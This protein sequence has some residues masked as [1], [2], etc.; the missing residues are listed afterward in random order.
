MPS[1]RRLIWLP[2]QV[3][4]YAVMAIALALPTFWEII[5]AL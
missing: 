2:I 5:D 3:G 1:R 4:L